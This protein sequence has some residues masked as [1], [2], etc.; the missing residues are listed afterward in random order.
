MK[1]RNEMI[2]EFYLNTK[3]IDS[4]KPRPQTGPN[5]SF[6]GEMSKPNKK[7]KK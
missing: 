5:A 6:M 1:T 4:S 2:R 3:K 7:E